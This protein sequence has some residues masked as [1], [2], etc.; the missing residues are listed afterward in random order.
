[1]ASTRMK[2]DRHELCAGSG[3]TTWLV[4]AK[5]IRCAMLKRLIVGQKH[6]LDYV[7]ELSGCIHSLSTRQLHFPRLCVPYKAKH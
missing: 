6:N 5:D 1:M 7:R 2:G 3:Y 4:L